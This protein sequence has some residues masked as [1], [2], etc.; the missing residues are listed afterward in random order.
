MIDADAHY[1]LTYTVSLAPVGDAP[2]PLAALRGERIAC[3]GT[4][5][6]LLTVAKGSD[7]TRAVQDMAQRIMYMTITDRGE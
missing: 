5:T 3:E 1:R 2:L 7:M 4:T 6:D